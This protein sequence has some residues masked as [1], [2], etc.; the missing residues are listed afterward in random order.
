[1]SFLLAVS[2]NKGCYCGSDRPYREMKV[3]SW[4]GVT[5]FCLN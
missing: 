3:I 2:V 1:M 5:S 4:D